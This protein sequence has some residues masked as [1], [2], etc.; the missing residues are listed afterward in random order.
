MKKLCII[1]LSILSV[2]AWGQLSEHPVRPRPMGI[3]MKDPVICYAGAA[4]D[5]L[6]V[7]PPPE[8]LAWRLSRASALKT[9]TIEVEYINFPP[10]AQAAF[11]N[12]VDIWESLLVSSVPIKIRAQWSNLAPGTL[13]SAIYTT[14][15]ANF[16][17][18]QKLN[19]FYPVAMA[20]KITG[21]NLNGDNPDIVAS[22][23]SGTDWHFDPNTPAP[24][25][26]YDLVTVVLHEICHGLGFAGSFSS[27]NNQGTVGLQA[28]SGALIPIVY[29]VAIQNGDN[30]VLLS[31][32][33]TALE[34]HQQLVSGDLFYKPDA[35]PRR[36]IYAPAS[37]NQGSSISHLNEGSFSGADALM[38][39]F[40]G[41]AET[42]HAPGISE[43]ILNDMGWE[44]VII[45]HRP[46]LQFENTSGEFP[47]TATFSGDNL[48]VSNPK[49]F[50]TLTGTAFTEVPM[51]A[52]GQP[53]EFT[54]NIPA[55]GIE[56]DYGYY[57]QAVDSKGK[58]FVNPGKVIERGN[59]PFQDFYIFRA[60]PDTRG[61]SII[62]SPKTFVLTSD[63]QLLLESTITDSTGVEG[64]RVEYLINDVPQPTLWLP[65]QPNDRYDF[66]I[67]LPA[68]TETDELKYRIIATDTATIGAASGNT[69]ILP[70]IGYYDVNVVS[71]LETVDTY[72]NDFE[73]GGD[74]FFGN[75]F[76]I[77]SPTGFN[78][79]N[80]IHSQHPYPA[81]DGQ[82]NNELNFTY[83]LRSPIRVSA[84][85][86]LATVIFDEIVLIEPGDAGSV[87]GDNDFYDYV[88]VEGSLDGGATWTP[89]ADGYDARANSAWLT[90]Y[91]SSFDTDQNSTAVGTP[92]L[93]RTR[94][95]NLRNAFDAGDEVV[96]RFRL[97]SDQLA[98]GWGWAIDNLKI[99]IDETAPLIRHD[100]VDYLKTGA[101]QLVLTT[102]PI[103]ASGIK[104]LAIEI[105]IDEDEPQLFPFEVNG[106][107]DEY[108]FNFALV[109]DEA[110]PEGMTIKYRFVAMDSAD[111]I[112]YFPPD[113]SFAHVPVL[114]F[115]EP[116]AQYANNFETTND[117]VGNFFSVNQ[118]A[119]FTN[120]LV[121]TTNP[122]PVGIGLNNT[123]DFVYMLTKPITISESNRYV[124]FDEI[125]LVEGHVGSIP[126]TNPNF[127][128]Y[129]IVEGSSD[130]GETWL[131]LINGYDINGTPEWITA[132]N[133]QTAPTP[134]LF[135]TRVFD[136]TG[137]GNFASGETILLRF[138]LFSNATINGWGWAID[139]L[140]IQD[141]I[142]NRE[143]EL[144]LAIKVYPNPTN[145]K[146]FIQSE[147]ITAT[148]VAVEVLDNTGRPVL[149]SITQPE[150]GALNL[151]LDMRDFANGLYFVRLSNGTEQHIRKIVKFN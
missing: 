93:Y 61:P 116:I 110:F 12:A 103:D 55:Q 64:V 111:N 104:T 44:T 89:I 45:N 76:S 122:Y 94:T 40:I 143:N 60:K 75:G 144:S 51:V 112:G 105:G 74:D 69:T 3:K 130:E 29:D 141:P 146:L 37:F 114:S 31:Q 71:L 83:Q 19:I 139:N 109:D 56:R 7:A 145:G 20:E 119:G 30:D 35:Q 15:Y 50:Y 6:Y 46:K 33:Y 73:A 39:P 113:G 41:E 151:E 150:N 136:L 85:A 18:A 38:T 62:H 124:R 5:S 53:N 90:A 125:V 142:T 72:A 63:T 107:I 21:Q 16:D 120:K 133:N 24:S 66:T 28:G 106:L 147:N 8:F 22:F 32:D 17:G 14:A 13:G 87:F 86:T 52:T 95:L 78:G 137:N 108:T 91:T 42:I 132:F 92:S 4:G 101:T 36:R 9:S 49:L 127:R 148:T 2:S 134:A 123:S 59:E 88:I 135:D 57:I 80:A 67:N 99:Q 43:D 27:S 140:Y 149:H 118:P 77:T 58:T 84:N 48:P 65:F 100:H 54:A 128:D 115:D 102:A 82:P 11:Q 68:L 1:L 26:K 10:S 97:Y 131:P 98:V 47:I 126:Y 96:L 117:F 138:R 25:G 121:K 81:G 79:N 23:N 34:L 70:E 129:V